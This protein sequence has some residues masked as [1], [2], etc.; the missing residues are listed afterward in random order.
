[1]I[2]DGRIGRYR[3]QRRLGSG[4]FATVWLAHD[5]TL[6][7]LVALKVLAENWA[8]RAD[9]CERFVEEARLLRR[10]DSEAV[11]R[12]FDIEHLPDGRPYFVMS[13]ANGGTLDERLAPGPLTL[14]AALATGVRVAEAA[15]DLNEAGII[16]RDLKPSNVLFHDPGSGERLLLA[17]LGLAKETA[18]AS[19]FTVAAGTPGYRAP[20]QARPGGGLDQRADVYAAAAVTYRMLTGRT[21]DA[22]S[23][24][25]GG[26][27]VAPSALRPEVPAVLDEVLSTALATDPEERYASAGAL[28]DALASVRTPSGAATPAARRRRLGWGGR[29][30][31]AGIVLLVA[32]LAGLAIARPGPI[33]TALAGG[34]GHAAPVRV[35]DAGNRISIAVPTG[36]HRR[37]QVRGGGWSPAA[38]GLGATHAPALELSPDLRHWRD[39]AGGDPGIFVGLTNELQRN[40][41]G[42]ATVVGHEECTRAAHPTPVAAGRLHGAE[43]RWNGCAGGTSSFIE[44]VLYPPGGAYG[45][46]VQI[47]Q[48]GD[49]DESRAILDSLRTTPP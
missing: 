26:T 49:R 11:A 1:V 30:A 46:Y 27:A 47:K 40:R 32:A 36:W 21:P 19:G 31:V 20:E 10:A 42:P 33:G 41:D 29:F 8:S 5:E 9:V 4:A 2:D 43:L 35:S 44:A 6:D 23:A 13:Y 14:D 39:P 16:H 17:D 22:A 48:V 3:L 18:Y 45:V 37:A 38:V 12:V 28:V 24:E 15:A 34:A 25:A 7:S